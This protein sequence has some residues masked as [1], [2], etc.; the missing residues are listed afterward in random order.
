M[1]YTIMLE[2]ID[3]LCEAKGIKSRQTAYLQSGVGKDFYANIRK[4]SKP[5]IEKVQA[6]A[7]YFGVSIDYLLGRTDN[8][9]QAEEFLQ[10]FFKIPKEKRELLLNVIKEFEN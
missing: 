1:D 3:S 8:D 10:L 4:G 7:N 6:L 2:R 5:S 9:P